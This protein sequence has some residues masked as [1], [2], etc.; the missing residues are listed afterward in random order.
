MTHLRITYTPHVYYILES[1]ISPNNLVK[2][3]ECMKITVF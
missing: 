3:E 1:F 2:A